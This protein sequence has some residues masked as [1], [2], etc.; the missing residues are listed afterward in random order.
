MG[1]YKL[2][3]G[4]SPIGKKRYCF[5][6]AANISVRADKFLT[7]A[8]SDLPT[9]IVAPQLAF[10]EGLRDVCFCG[11]K[12]TLQYTNPC[13]LWA[14]SGH[15]AVPA[16][17]YGRLHAFSFDERHCGRSCEKMDK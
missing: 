13:P 12:P 6:E 8:A 1:P 2:L 16:S 7:A 5:D 17:S 9:K 14:N 3:I 10:L 15:E 11:R 4:T